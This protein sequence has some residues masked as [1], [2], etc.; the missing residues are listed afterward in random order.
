MTLNEYKEMT[1]L[2]SIIEKTI[3]YIN[4]EIK[5][6]PKDYVEN[7]FKKLYI[8]GDDVFDYPNNT[9]NGIFRTHDAIVFQKPFPFFSYKC[10]IKWG[11]TF[12]KTWF[13]INDSRLYNEKINLSKLDM[14]A[15]EKLTII[16]T[17]I[18]LTLLKENK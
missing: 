17:N 4:K 9:K 15:L 5:K 7:H 10:Y 2:K 6:L 14:V 8:L 18:L 13:D 12:R 11:C 3:D 1:D 16:L